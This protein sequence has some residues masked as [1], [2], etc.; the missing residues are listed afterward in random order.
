MANDNIINRKEAHLA[1]SLLPQMRGRGPGLDNI[2]LC[3][4]ADFP[5][6]DSML[7]TNVTICG[8]PLNFPLVIGSMTGGTPKASQ[9]NNTLRRL[10]NRYGIAL[11]LGSIRAALADKTLIS[12]YGT[13][14][15]PCILGNIGI[16]EI[17]NQTYSVE[18]IRETLE[19]LGCCA[20]YIHLNIIQEWL[21]PGGNACLY[22]DIDRLAA[23]IN[24]IRIPVII[25]EVGSGIG[26]NCAN[27]LAKLNIYGLETA[28]LGG[29]SWVNIEAARRNGSDSLLP[30]NINALN[31]IGIPLEAAIRDC[32]NAL[33]TRTVIASGG[34]Q[35][36]LTIIKCLALGADAVSIAQPIYDV[37]QKSGE[38]GLDHWIS[39]MIVVSRLIWRSTGAKDIITLREKIAQSQQSI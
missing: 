32:R 28:S 8:K 34:I 35:D 11:G 3:Y 33:K 16:S 21:Q 22:T 1:L 26:G 7:N 9:F 6:S 23:F 29:T 4:E 14:H 10:S 27:R 37:Y 18:Q 5:I 2:N 19:I 31:N 38:E 17:I 25:K 15:A 13:H 12:T 24:D 20:L 30:L 39:E 36:A